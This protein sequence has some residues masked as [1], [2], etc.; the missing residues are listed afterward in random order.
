MKLYEIIEIMNNQHETSVLTEELF[1]YKRSLYTYFKDLFCCEPVLMVTSVTNATQYARIEPS[2]E[3][4][5]AICTWLDDY[6]C[7]N[8][9]SENFC[10]Y[11]T[12][13][14]NSLML[15]DF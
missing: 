1:K 4:N 11:E 15:K 14:A 3:F 7:D 13:C 8:E 9:N 2:N 10:E 6:E 5:E 12:I